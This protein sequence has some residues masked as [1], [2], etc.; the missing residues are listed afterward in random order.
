[1]RQFD[2]EKQSGCV[3]AQRKRI[4]IKS[5]IKIKSLSQNLEEKGTG[6]FCSED[7]AK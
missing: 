7:S 6:T 3:G 5:T 1:M 2:H 4:K